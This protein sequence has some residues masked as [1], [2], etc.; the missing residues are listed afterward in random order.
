MEPTTPMGSRRTYEVW[1]PEYSPADWPWRCR[2]APA[3]KA[4]LS[5]VPG[6]SNSRAQ[7]DRLAALQGLGAGELLGALGEHGGEAV[8]GVGALARGGAGP[9]R[10]RRAGG[11]DGRVHVGGAGQFVACTPPRRSPGRRPRGYGRRC[12]SRTARD[13]L[14]ARRRSAPG[15]GTGPGWHCPG[16][17]CRSPPPSPRVRGRWRSSSSI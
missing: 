3:K 15:P 9:A 7:L 4:V 16:C 1:S 13:E 5:I 12:P 14:R 2:A 11:G 10:E 8:Q 6:T 17:A